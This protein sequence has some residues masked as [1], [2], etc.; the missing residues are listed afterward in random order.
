MINIESLDT[1]Y[2]VNSAI[3]R[4]DVINVGYGYYIV[5]F[6]MFFS[7][8]CYLIYRVVVRT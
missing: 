2:R 1:L 6:G 4:M 8:Y 7:S 5:S 3:A